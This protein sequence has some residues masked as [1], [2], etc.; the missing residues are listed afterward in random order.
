MK[1][2]KMNE[3][4]TINVN[5]EQF[6]ETASRGSARKHQVLMDR[7]EVKGGGDKG[8]MGGEF[9][10]MSLG[11]CFM[12][13]LLAAAKTRDVEL[14]GAA[15]DITG[16]IQGTPSRFAAISMKLSI[17]GTDQALLKKLVTIA[18]RGCLVANTLKP[19]LE[20]TI[21]INE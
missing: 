17:D 18:E 21:D 16:T 8:P 5:V 14:S 7:P 13:N 11:G 20:L 10:L 6:G 2:D 9:F 3:T 4:M 19:A 12:S 1:G 15:L